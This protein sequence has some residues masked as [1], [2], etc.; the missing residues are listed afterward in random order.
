MLECGPAVEE[1]GAPTAHYEFI[2]LSFKPCSKR[3]I[4]RYKTLQTLKG[5]A[6]LKKVS[7]GGIE[8]PCPTH[9]ACGGGS[10]GFSFFGIIY[11][12]KMVRRRPPQLNRGLWAAHGPVVSPRCTLKVRR[13]GWTLCCRTIP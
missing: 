12:L 3:S 8:K 5:A 9:G 1:H 7:V 13:G 10:G 2:G 6:P 4:P 11:F